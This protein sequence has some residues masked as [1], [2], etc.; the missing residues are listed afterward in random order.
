MVRAGVRCGVSII[1][2]GRSRLELSLSENV[3]T[4]GWNTAGIRSSD[5]RLHF[6]SVC[7]R[8]KRQPFRSRFLRG[9]KNQGKF[10]RSFASVLT[11][12]PF[13]LRSFATLRRLWIREARFSSRVFRFNVDY[14]C[15][16]FY[17]IERPWI[18]STSNLPR[19]QMHSPSLS[20][21]CCNAVCQFSVLSSL[22]KAGES[23]KIFGELEK[24]KK[25]F[26]L[27]RG[28]IWYK[29]I[30]KRNCSNDKSTQRY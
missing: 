13:P 5:G 14:P 7:L 30:G 2:A 26:L 27:L 25:M 23:W 12:C 28:E 22:R 29:N 16:R 8:E 24:I 9:E 6:S 15:A 4:P 20:L 19:K 21:K 17:L 11:P 1:Y 18:V 3:F 10:L